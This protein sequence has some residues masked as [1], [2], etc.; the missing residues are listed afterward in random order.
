MTWNIEIENIAGILSGSTEIQSGLNAVR[1]SNW[2]GK[3]SFIESIKTGLG[4][5]TSLT[6]GKERGQVHL[7]TPE[8]DVFVELVRKNGTVHRNGQPY[9][10]DEYDVIRTLLFS[11]LDEQNEIRRAVREGENL[12]EVLM[13]PLD[14]QNIDEQIA[15]LKR[16]RDQIESEFAQAKEAKNRLPSVQE[17]VTRIETELE[18]LREDY[19]ELTGPND[20]KQ[21]SSATSSQSQLAQARS[22]RD[23]AENQIER[24]E[25]SIQRLESRLQDKQTELEDIEVVEDNNVESELVAARDQLQDTKRDAEVLQSV[26]SANEMVL[27]ENRLDLLS[28]VQR[29][30]TGDKISCW[31][32]GNETRR[33]EVEDQLDDLGEKIVDLRSKIKSHR[34][35][36]EQL[37]AQRED[38]KQSR[39]RKQDLESEIGALKDNLA[40]HE[41][42]LED[43]NERRQNAQQRVEE[44]SESVDETVEKITDIES[45]IKYREAELKD[46]QDELGALESRAN[47]MEMLETERDELISE[48]EDLR[49]RKDQI[50]YEAREAFDEAMKEIITRF[51]TGFETARLTSEFDLVVAR[52]GREASLDALSE[53]EL[54]LLGFVTALAGHKSFD[55]ADV[56]PIMLVDGVGG[57]DDENLHTLIDYL[58]ERVDY[59]VFTIYPEYTS[60]E[61]AE[62]DPS[63]WEVAT[64]QQA[65]AD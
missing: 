42:S 57:L 43:A 3:S 65:T 16:E 17:K 49:N 61:G 53:G 59:L 9:L 56:T 60:F 6:E 55:V 14:F 33:S 23:K 19:D 24:L 13:R 58:Q 4:V 25:R 7:Q 18:A 29:E 8:H 27:N 54:E 34:D 32:C 51:D 12:E 31:I 20:E 5:S 45:D 47:Q 40:D 35:E 2:Q 46:V 1:A 44:L 63:D 39:R 28:E 11:C 64:D 52:G 38:I 36:V 41:Q 50:K 22:E 48:I 15:D 37:E 10:E 21:A 26:Y 62:I 30:L